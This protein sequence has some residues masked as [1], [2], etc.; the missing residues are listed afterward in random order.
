MSG[1][2]AEVQVDGTWSKNAQVWPDWDSADAAGRDLLS[3]WFVPTDHR[4]VEVEKL[5]NY[6]TWTEH[7]CRN[8][9]PPRSV[10]L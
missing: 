3:R 5:P 6:P 8:G 2:I 1:F 4:V 10:S 7:V 9:L